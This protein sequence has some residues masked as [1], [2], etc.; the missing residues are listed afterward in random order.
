MSRMLSLLEISPL[1]NVADP[2]AVKPPR[3][4]LM[5]LP[6]PMWIPLSLAPLTS[7]PHSYYVHDSSI[8][9]LIFL[10]SSSLYFHFPPLAL[11]VCNYRFVDR[12]PPKRK[13]TP[14]RQTRRQKALAQK[15]DGT[16][17]ELASDTILTTDPAHADPPS[18]GEETSSSVEIGKKRAVESTNTSIL[19]KKGSESP[20]KRAKTSIQ[21][22]AATVDD[23]MGGEKKEEKDGEESTSKG[24]KSGEKSDLDATIHR[25]LAMEGLDEA[26]KKTL[27]ALEKKRVR[28]IRF[29]Q[30][31][32][33][34]GEDKRA[35]RCVR[36]G[37]VTSPAVKSANEEKLATAPKPIQQK[38]SH[39]QRLQK[40]ADR[41]G[42]TS[43]KDLL[44]EKRAERFGVAEKK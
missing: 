3:R 39:M 7:L 12:M 24:E 30:P 21:E 40:R 38:A 11:C 27:E 19:S 14:Q 29:G 15:R 41:F 42:Q 31:L 2:P 6:D 25:G 32:V 26:T 8:P 17:T 4:T 43:A 33:L 9:A 20:T 37:I 16:E 44:L 10:I 23:L 28:G 18:T 34:S 1:K 36:F 35:L 13:V 5:D 22:G